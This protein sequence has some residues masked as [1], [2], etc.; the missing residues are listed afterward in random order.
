MDKIRVA[1]LQIMPTGTME[2]NLEKGLEYCRK[3]SELEADIALFPEMWNCGYR[4]PEDRETLS[5]L[6]LTRKSPFL[7]SYRQLARELNMAIGITYLEAGEGRKLPK[8]SLP[9]LTGG[10][11]R[12]ILIPR[13]TPVISGR[14]AGSGRGRISM[15][16]IWIRRRARSRWAA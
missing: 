16:R 9:C 10:A 5:A 6:A 13:Y 14:N 3:A 1:M 7:E 12:H 15:W 8:N 2:G 4:I 11:G